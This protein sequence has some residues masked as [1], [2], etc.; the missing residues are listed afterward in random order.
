MIL[1]EG[2]GRAAE[3]FSRRSFW[4]MGGLGEKSSEFYGQILEYVQ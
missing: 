1:N 3:L 4:V 2:S